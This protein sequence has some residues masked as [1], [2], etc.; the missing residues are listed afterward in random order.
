MSWLRDIFIFWPGRLFG[1]LKNC[2]LIRKVFLPP[3]LVLEFGTCCNHHWIKLTVD[4]MTLVSYSRRRVIYHG[5][6]RVN[7]VVVASLTSAVQL[8]GSTSSW[9]SSVMS[10]TRAWRHLARRVARDIIVTSDRSAPKSW[11]SQIMNFQNQTIIK[12]DTAI[13]MKACH[14]VNGSSITAVSFLWWSMG[15]VVFPPQGC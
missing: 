3:K 11:A 5:W 4:G 1:G 8:Q 14:H 12:G 15:Q 10:L 7:R 13:F 2:L 9:L 6:S